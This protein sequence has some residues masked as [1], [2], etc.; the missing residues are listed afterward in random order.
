VSIHF[1][2]VIARSI[3]APWGGSDA[4]FGTNPMCVGVPL[5]Q[6]EPFIL[7][8]ATSR[9]A[10]GKMRVAHNK[11]NRVDEGL[12]IDHRGQPTI[13]PS[14]VVTP[15]TDANGQ[16]QW[17]AILPFGEH[18]GSG[19]AMACELLAGALTGGGT[20]HRM[21]DA[22]RA[23]YNSML[24]IVIDP[25]AAHEQSFFEREA[26]AFIDWCKASPSASNDAPVLFAGEPERAKR[27]E[28]ERDGIEIDDGTWMELETAAKRFDVRLKV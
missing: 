19:L 7:D 6:R 9:V 10:Q 2:N 20:W 26:A 1:V 27:V 22:K 23:V 21:S 14:V 15:K 28:R 18:K 5:G 4:R 3:V 16:P 25:K 11:S 17:G 24:S 13:D 12:L 8:F